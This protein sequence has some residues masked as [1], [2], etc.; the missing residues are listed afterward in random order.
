[1]DQVAKNLETVQLDAEG[2]LEMRRARFV[3]HCV[4][5]NRGV[6]C[7]SQAPDQHP[8]KDQLTAKKVRQ[9]KQLIEI[10]VAMVQ[11]C[12]F[13]VSKELSKGMS[14]VVPRY[15]QLSDVACGSA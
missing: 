11:H 2:S 15:S 10:T 9:P 7:V 13:Q 14:L 12:R 3:Q 8:L 6:P 5:S 1:M 4:A